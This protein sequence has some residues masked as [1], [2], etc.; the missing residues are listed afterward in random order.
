MS[1]NKRLE[2]LRQI[3]KIEKENFAQI[4]K[5][6]NYRSLQSAINRSNTISMKILRE[7]KS[8]KPN[9]N[10]NWLIANQGNMFLDEEA[11]KINQG[12]NNNIQVAQGTSNTQSNG[13]SAELQI[14]VENL[15]KELKLAQ[16][17]IITL[18]EK[19]IDTLEK[20]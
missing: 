8:Y 13:S 15:T 18:Q 17:K 16:K 19:L 9:I 14:Q 11:K 6:S 10:L 3:L 2:Q 7:I 20:K 5:Y 1:E 12:S 4:L